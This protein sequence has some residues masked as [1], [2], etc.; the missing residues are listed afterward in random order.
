MTAAQS[1]RDRFAGRTV[2]VTGGV[3]G[4]GLSMT[5]AFAREGANVVAAD[6][7][8]ENEDFE[9]VRAEGGEVSYVRTDVTDRSWSTPF[10]ANRLPR[11]A[12]CSHS[13]TVNVATPIAKNRYRYRQD[14]RFVS[15]P[16][17]LNWRNF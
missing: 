2:I 1:G 10:V 13:H 15:M 5:T 9:K 12:S 6:V 8:P 14:D 16:P 17:A 11:A 7:G 4:I 3:S